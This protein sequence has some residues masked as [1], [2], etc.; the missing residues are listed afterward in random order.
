[1]FVHHVFFWL[2][3]E[4]SQQDVDKFEKGVK[5]LLSIEGLITGDVGKP[6]S[7]DRPIIDNSYSFSLLTIFN[8]KDAHDTYQDHPVH[9]KFLEECRHLSAKILVYDSET[10]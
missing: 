9:H 4:L 6:A 7:T 10:V 5:S 1:M 2:R 8:D 3:K